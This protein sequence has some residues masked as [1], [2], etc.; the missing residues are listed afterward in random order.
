VFAED[1]P[2]F[3]FRLRLH[4]R[5]DLR[6]IWVK[7]DETGRYMIP[8][9]PGEYRL[10]GWEKG[11]G[12]PRDLRGM[13]HPVDDSWPD[14]A[15]RVLNVSLDSPTTVPAL[16]FVKGVVRRAPLGGD[17]VGPHV[18]LQWEAHPEARFYWVCIYDRGESPWSYDGL[19]SLPSA[20]VV[21]A[22]STEVDLRP[23]HYYAWEVQAL[24]PEY[25]VISRSDTDEISFKV[26]ERR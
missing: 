18:V 25:R 16:R 17:L 11:Q 12:L 19:V 10:A 26:G 9:P 4:L 2:V 15:G 23:G 3:W 21:T 5:P 20:K 1:K 8:V 22:T 14:S 13:T 7:T 6:T 24:D